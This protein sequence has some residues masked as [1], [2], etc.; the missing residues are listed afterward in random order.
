M[1]GW[2]FSTQWLSSSAENIVS[3]GEV[4]LSFLSVPGYKHRIEDLKRDSNNRVVA[5]SGDETPYFHAYERESSYYDKVFN[6]IS[7]L[8]NGW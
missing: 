6:L 4:T 5:R 3:S 1:N 7:F 8:K 2:D